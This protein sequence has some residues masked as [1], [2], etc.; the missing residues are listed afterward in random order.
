MFHLVRYFYSWHHYSTLKTIVHAQ[1]LAECDSNEAVRCI[2]SAGSEVI[3]KLCATRRFCGV[4]RFCLNLL[5]GQA[6]SSRH[7]SY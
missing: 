7:A 4:A 1:T 3:L 5:R 2:L 6:V